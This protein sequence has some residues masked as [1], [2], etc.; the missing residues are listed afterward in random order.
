MGDQCFQDVDVD[1]WIPALGAEQS[2]SCL[3]IRAA[4]GEH[5]GNVFSLV[6]AASFV[7][8]APLNL[9]ELAPDFVALSFN[10]SFEFPDLGALIVRISAPC[11]LEKRKFFDGGTVNVVLVSEAQWHAKM[12]ISI[13]KRLEDGTLPFHRIIPLDAAFDTDEHL[14]FLPKSYYGDLAMQSPIIAFSLKDSQGKWIPKS[15]I[16]SLAAAELRLHYAQGL[17]CGDSHDVLD[18]R[19]TS[20][21]RIS[22]EAMTSVN[23]IRTLVHFIEENAYVDNF[24]PVML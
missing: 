21:L 17:R 9:K 5:E 14:D 1:T 22:L 20:V 18:A 13:H 2:G 7:S 8:T 15:D 23:Y 6:D 12:T 24:L 10:K 11:A 4:T 19:P 16:E 3:L